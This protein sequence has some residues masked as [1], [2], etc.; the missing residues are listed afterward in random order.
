MLALSVNHRRRKA[1]LEVELNVAAEIALVDEVDEALPTQARTCCGKVCVLGGDLRRAA[2]KS[3]GE[4]H[5][6]N[7]GEVGLSRAGRID[8][9]QPVE[10]QRPCETELGVDRVTPVE[11]AG[12]LRVASTECFASGRVGDR[13]VEPPKGIGAVA[14]F[15]FRCEADVARSR[16]PRRTGRRRGG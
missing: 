12:K 6:G 5:A 4:L 7:E 8:S 15:V 10:A 13:A 2:R 9:A 1:I 16:N 14:E 11:I 3:S